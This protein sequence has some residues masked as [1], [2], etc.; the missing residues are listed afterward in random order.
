[1]TP[2]VPQPLEEVLHMAG[3]KVRMD[4]LDMDVRIKAEIV[5][6]KLGIKEEEVMTQPL[7]MLEE[8]INLRRFLSPA[9][10]LQLLSKVKEIRP[11][12]GAAA[13]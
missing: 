7:A 13:A 11:E 9:Q 8:R 1:M 5:S 10:R 4:Q 12:P 2:V 6:E 3:S